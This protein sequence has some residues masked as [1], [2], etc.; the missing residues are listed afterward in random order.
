MSRTQ[1]L[2]QH[3]INQFI[4]AIGLETLAS[5]LPSQ[6]VMAEMFNISRTT[7]MHALHYLLERGVLAREGTRY[8]IAR[9]P[10]GADGFEVISETLEEQTALFEKQFR[11]LV[12]QRQIVPG[13]A[14]SE[15]Q[16]ARQ[17]RVRPVV[18]REFLLRF[19]RYDLLESL[20]RGY[21]RVKPFGRLDAE[22]LFELRELLETYALNVFMNLATAIRAGLR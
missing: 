21:W 18:V 5:P 13:D 19:S 14:F 1:T 11:L 16:L 22:Q 12:A 17:C 3:A 7:V 15:L 8:V 6:A 4:D 10:C 9:A 20:R 2:R